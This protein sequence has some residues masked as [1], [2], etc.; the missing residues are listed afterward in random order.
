MITIR[1]LKKSYGRTQAVRG[2]DLDIESG[3]CFGL[4]GPNGA[5]KT[6]TLKVLATL[7]K[8]DFGVALIDDHDVVERPDLIRK[9]VG[10]MPDIFQS[11]GD[12]KI[13]HYLDYFAALVGLRGKARTRK[14]TQ[15]LELT[16]LTPKKDEL[17]G[18][19]SRGNKQRL[20]LAKTLLHNPKVLLLDEPASGLDPRARIEIR[21]LLKELKNMGKTILISSHI[22][23]DLQEICDRV[24]IYEAGQ[25]VRRGGVQDL[26]SEVRVASRLRIHT[27]ENADPAVEVLQG[28]SQVQECERQSDTEVLLTL[29]NDSE[30]NDILRALIDKNIGLEAFFEDRPALADVFLD[31][32]KG[33]I[34]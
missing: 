20:C 11:Y 8:P 15:V 32:T 26:V 12:T 7:V 21:M 22:L 16:D 4:I 10:F 28:L 1:R 25:I 5:G 6:T 19:L 9:I 29:N 23:E 30:T 27:K 17:V 14:V 31:L 2:I 3:E 24:A 33:E 34:S 13:L 18:G